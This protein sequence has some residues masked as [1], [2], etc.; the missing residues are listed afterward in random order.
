VSGGLHTH[1]NLATRTVFFEA[2]EEELVSLGVVVERLRTNHELPVG[3]D[4][5]SDVLAFG[6]ID[7]AEALVSFFGFLMG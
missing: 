4:N 7:A 5:A 1:E 6:H 3:V 2:I